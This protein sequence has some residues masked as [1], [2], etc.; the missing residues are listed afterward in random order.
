[1]EAIQ[2]KITIFTLIKAN[3]T[4]NTGNN[5]EQKF[6]LGKIHTYRYIKFVYEKWDTV[7]S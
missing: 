3:I 4:I 1:M 7:N 5:N 6:E 2:A